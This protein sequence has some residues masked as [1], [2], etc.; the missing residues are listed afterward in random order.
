MALQDIACNTWWCTSWNWCVAHHDTAQVDGHAVV[1]KY[2]SRLVACKD[3]ALSAR[4]EKSVERI[5]QAMGP[6]S[7][8]EEF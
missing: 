2:A 4:V 7:Q 6:C 3:A 5:C 1:V 8:G